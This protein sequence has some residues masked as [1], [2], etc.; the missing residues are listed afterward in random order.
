MPAATAR[1]PR[2]PP[3]LAGLHHRPAGPADETTGRADQ[4]AQ[5]QGN[6]GTEGRGGHH[7][8][9]LSR[10][11]PGIALCLVETLLERLQ[12]LAR[13]RGRDTRSVGNG[14]HGGGALVGRCIL[15]KSGS[16]RRHCAG[17]I[18]G[19][20]LGSLTR[21]IRLA[22]ARNGVLAIRPCGVGRLRGR[23]GRRA[24]EKLRDLAADRIGKPRIRLRC[25][26]GGRLGQPLDRTADRTEGAAH[27]CRGTAGQEKHHHQG[28][29]RPGDDAVQNRVGSRNAARQAA[30]SIGA[31][32][33]ADQD[34]RD[35]PQPP[36]GQERT[37][38]PGG[39]SLDAGQ[40]DAQ[41][42]QAEHELQRHRQQRTRDD[43]PPGDARQ[44]L[45]RGR[46][47]CPLASN[48]THVMLCPAQ[49]A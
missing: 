3:S 15:G 1:G 10:R 46:S 30:G 8:R 38:I 7:L 17:K 20:G 36:G 45:C 28:G 31:D 26:R 5:Q 6:E 14:L 43:R 41:T 32:E 24:I 11:T 39:G 47:H 27:H 13:L 16:D 2:S 40:A 4:Q 44:G 37:R 34:H 29:G 12:P 18:D 35:G 25:R 33:Q 9:R 42:Q 23:G 21:D 22:V 49:V 48:V 19:S